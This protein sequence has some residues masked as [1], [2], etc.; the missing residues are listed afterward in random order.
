M[1]RL[2]LVLPGAGFLALIALLALALPARAQLPRVEWPDLPAHLEA[3]DALIPSAELGVVEC[4]AEMARSRPSRTVLQWIENTFYKW[5]EY[6]VGDAL[7]QEAFCIVMARPASAVLSREEAR[8]LLSASA[9]WRRRALEV[10]PVEAADPSAPELNLPAD[11]GPLPAREAASPAA[12][13]AMA[14]DGLGVGVLLR[15]G[16]PK[17]GAGGVEPPAAGTRTVVGSDDRGRVGNTQTYPWYNIAYISNHYPN[18]QSFRGTGFLAGPYALLTNAHNVYND[19]RGGFVDAFTLYP[20]QY[21]TSPGGTVFRPFGSRSAVR[22]V[23]NTNYTATGETQYDYAAANFSTPV[24]GISTYMPLVFDQTL[25]PGNGINLAG[26]PAS[27]QGESNSRA[28]WHG[29]G[30]VRQVVGRVLEHY[31]DTSGGNSGSPIWLFNSGTGERRVVAIHAFG[32]TS[33]PIYNGGPRLVSQNQGLIEQWL[34]WRPGGG[35]T[36]PCV[37]GTTTLCIDDDPGDRRFKV[38]VFYSTTQGGGR[39][40]DAEATS[41]ASL[42]IGKGGVLSFFDASNPEM[43]VKVVRGCGLTDHFWV[44]VAATTNVGFTVTVEDTETGFT[45][46]YT[47][48]DRTPAVP[49]QDTSAIP[50]P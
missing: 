10:G 9:L 1:R 48:P 47:N 39:S 22:V 31:V 5:H 15:G 4:P 29:F 37:P 46:I 25:A 21:Q 33:A 41:L 30:E 36:G 50:C 38:T 34:A 23:T 44:F 14:S 13:V 28:M 3:A 17:A 7:G 18:D 12:P 40:G 42:G 49:V 43:L 16:G 11:E 27:V 2:E 24:A 8:V 26:Y 20:G 45:K 32:R 6:D 19:T 35:G